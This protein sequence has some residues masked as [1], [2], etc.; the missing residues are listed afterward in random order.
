MRNTKNIL[1]GTNNAQNTLK[2]KS[3]WKSDLI[4]VA[5]ENRRKDDVF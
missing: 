2:I 4:N 5:D 3:F 1:T